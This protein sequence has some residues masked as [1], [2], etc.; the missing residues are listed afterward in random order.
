MALPGVGGEASQG[1]GVRPALQ[2]PLPWASSWDHRGAWLGRVSPFPGRALLY[3][4][5][6]CLQGMDI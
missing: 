4:G 6:P 1:S 5:G 3:L 2:V